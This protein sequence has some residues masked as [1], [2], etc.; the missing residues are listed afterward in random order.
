MH[1]RIAWEIYHHQAKQ[2][3]EKA[4]AVKP[5]EMLRPP[6]HM[7]PPSPSARPHEM[8]QAGPGYPPPSQSLQGRNPFDPNPLSASFL[9]SPSSHLGKSLSHTAITKSK[10]NFN[11]FYFRRV[12][13]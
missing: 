13:V 1:V 9:T 4:A 10:F 7:Y 3:P 6:S 2:N 5:P 8:Q 12:S 11:S